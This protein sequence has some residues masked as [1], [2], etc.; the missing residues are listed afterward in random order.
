MSYSETLK[1]RPFRNLWLGQ[2]ISQLGDAFYYVSFMFMV[3]KVTG[4]I[5]M[6]GFVGACETLP[7]LLLSLYAGVVADRLDR[8]VIMLWSDLLSGISLCVLGG[9]VFVLGKPPIWSLLL[10]PFLLSCVRSFFMPAKSAAIPALVPDDQLMPANA[11]S[12]ITQSIVPMISLAFTAGVLS[13]FYSWS[14]KWFLISAVM[15][16]SVSF[17][18]S[19]AFVYLLPTILPIR[20]KLVEA[21]PWNDLKDG[22]RFIRSNHALMVLLALQT[23][24]SLS[25]SP[26]FVVYV[27]ANKDWFGGKPQTLAIFE[28][29]FFA[30]MF[31]A[32]LYVGK[33]QFKRP[34]IGFIGGAFG[35]G[36]TVLI[37]AFS[38]IFALFVF[39]CLMAGVAVPFADIPMRTWMQ[40]AIP[41]GF[42]GRTNSV[43]M[44]LA[45]GVAPSGLCLGGVLV[46]AVGISMAFVLMGAG[47]ALAALL[48]LVDREFR[49]LKV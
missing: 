26:F 23:G 31:L 28:L 18:A 36:I 19:A 42:R 37:L 40:M 24:F 21:H 43:F 44:M 33:M 1:I 49:S 16:N 15:L 8:R 22:L 4:S 41:D 45:A 7:Y 17:F 46:T 9:L 34:G 10:I 13:F 2:A 29:S 3:Q 35:V 39:W 14:P 6:V 32:S 27:A 30:G 25:V 48:G 38:K 12:G 11:L 20:E 47:M 5:A